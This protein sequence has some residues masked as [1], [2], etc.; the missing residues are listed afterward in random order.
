MSAPVLI[1]YATKYGS[2]QD[3]ATT[4]AETLREQGIVVDVKAISDVRS[5]DTY[6]S[7][8]IGSPIY[9]GRWLP[10]VE[11]FLT[12]QQKALQERPVAIFTLG[13]I[14]VDPASAGEAVEQFDQEVA[15]YAWLHPILTGLFGGKYDPSRLSLAHRL[16]AKIPGTPLHG[17]PFHDARDQEAIRSWT[18]ELTEKLDLAVA[19]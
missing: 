13:M 11:R 10:D 14:N 19:A 18:T 17:R 3:V 16:M 6:R 2:T 7:V 4:V 15:R 5:I 1:A 9:M 12:K 8:V